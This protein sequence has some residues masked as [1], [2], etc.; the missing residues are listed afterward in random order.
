LHVHLGFLEL[1]LETLDLVLGLLNSTE[2]A[3]L[4]GMN[5]V[6]LGLERA[7]SSCL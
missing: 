3:L 1:R 2:S 7:S 5:L 6:Q 4:L